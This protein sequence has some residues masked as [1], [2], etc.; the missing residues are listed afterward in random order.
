M[1]IYELTKLLEDLAKLLKKHNKN[2]DLTSNNPAQIT[3]DPIASKMLSKETSDPI[4]YPLD[5][6][7]IKQ[8]NLNSEEDNDEK[9]QMIY[10][11]K[12]MIINELKKTMVKPR[13][14]KV[15]R[16]Q[17][18][19][20]NTEKEVLKYEYSQNIK[21]GQQENHL[22]YL[23]SNMK[24]TGS[25]TFEDERN[26]KRHERDLKD[27]EISNDKLIEKVK[28][29]Q[30][31]LTKNKLQ[32][33]YEEICSASKKTDKF[34]KKYTNNYE[35]NKEK[36]KK[37]TKDGTFDFL[38]SP[39]KYQKKIQ[40]ELKKNVQK[41]NWR[42]KTANKLKREMVIKRKKEIED[43][44]EKK[45]LG[46]REKQANQDVKK[47]EIEKKLRKLMILFNLELLVRFMNKISSEGNL[48][49]LF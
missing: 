21:F 7:S 18:L 40:G 37:E 9:Q 31:S 24:K 49:I 28:K 25:K 17:N 22:V 42:I 14:D 6:I 3:Y 39:E 10:E 1:K 4:Y 15:I 34:L 38:Q 36:I 27:F 32:E 11:S 16:Q 5:I 43:N 13:S 29:T 35:K 12:K 48:Y 44:I 33:I 19:L 47:K 45:S 23:M 2:I 26:K 46:Y 30:D 8:N 20:L 41:R